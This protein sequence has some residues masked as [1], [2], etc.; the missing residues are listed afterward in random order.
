MLFLQNILGKKSNSFTIA[1]IQIRLLIFL[2]LFFWCLGFFLPLLGSITNNTSLL[3]WFVSY[4]YSLVCHQS[5]PNGINLFNS[6]LLVCTRCAGIYLGAL[7]STFFLLLGSRRLNLNRKLIYIF[8]I[9]II[10]DAV[11]I[12]A[13]FYPYSQFITFLTGILFG[14][15]VILFIIEA[16]EKSFQFSK[17]ISYDS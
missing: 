6:N 8:A 14:T 9:P 17:K 10:F 2:L 16:I 3:I 12:R 1:S 4:N 15:I 11:S 13:G 5:E 7:L